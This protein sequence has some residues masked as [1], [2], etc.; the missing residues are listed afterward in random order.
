MDQ[1]T[2]KANGK[3]WMPTPGQLPSGGTGPAAQSGEMPSAG[4]TTPA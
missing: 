2:L 3:S 1:T 4:G